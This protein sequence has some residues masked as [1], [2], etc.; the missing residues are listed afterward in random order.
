VFDPNGN[1]LLV[2]TANTSEGVIAYRR[3][4]DSFYRTATIE[5]P[6]QINDVAIDSFRNY[7]VAGCETSNPT[8]RICRA[9]R[10][11]KFYSIN[12]LRSHRIL[13]SFLMQERSLKSNTIKS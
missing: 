1:Y 13:K 6:V 2:A 7:I 10:T 3:K 9:F 5:N 4:G 12:Q 8:L 11:Y